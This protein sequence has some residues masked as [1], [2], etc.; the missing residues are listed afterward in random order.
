MNE[1]LTHLLVQQS[2]MAEK[3]DYF[4]SKWR[5]NNIRIHQVKEESEG[6]DMVK[7]LDELISVKLGIPQNELF[8]TAAHRSTPQKKP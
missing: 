2:L 6:A 8:I 3:L 4:E 1:I 7:F 5:Q